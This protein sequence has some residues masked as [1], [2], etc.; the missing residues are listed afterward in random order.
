[1]V[2]IDQGLVVQRLDNAIH[3]INC[4]PAVDSVIQPLNNRGLIVVPWK[5]DALKTSIFTLKASLLGLSISTWTI[6]VVNSA[7]DL[8]NSH[9]IEILSS[10][11]LN[12]NTSGS[13]EE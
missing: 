6:Q 8:I 2:T 5:F 4:Y 7:F 13:L 9:P 12:R 1:M 3:W 10:L 11:M